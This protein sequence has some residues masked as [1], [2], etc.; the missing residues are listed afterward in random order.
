MKYALTHACEGTGPLSRSSAV[1]AMQTSSCDTDLTEEEWQLMEP[2]F[3]PRKR[4]GRPPTPLRPLLN[5][6][7]YLV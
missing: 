4:M 6:I 5:P 7:L 3:P 2:L 1:G